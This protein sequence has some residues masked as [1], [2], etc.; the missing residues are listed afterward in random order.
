MRVQCPVPSGGTACQR[1][2]PENA[3]RGGTGSGI[4]K[5]WVEGVA[6]RA[7]SRGAHTRRQAVCGSCSGTCKGW[8][9]VCG[10]CGWQ[11]AEALAIM[12]RVIQGKQQQNY[13]LTT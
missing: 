5:P 6:S 9:A 2:L 3:V 8:L 12:M 1:S 10:V 13:V 7:R 4:S 11:T